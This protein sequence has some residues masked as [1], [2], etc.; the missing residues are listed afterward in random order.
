MATAISCLSS[1]HALL[2][3]SPPAASTKLYTITNSRHRIGFG[4][5]SKNGRYNMGSVTE[6]P[7]GSKP[8]T[9]VAESRRA[10]TWM[11]RASS[12]I[13]QTEKSAENLVD[14][15]LSMVEGTDRGAM[16]RRE[17]HEKIARTISQLELFCM[18]EPLKSPLI[19]GEWDVEY[20]SNPTSTGGYY[21][22]AVGRLFLRTKEMGQ[23]IQAPDF[24]GNKVSFSALNAID[25]EVSLKGRLKPLDNKWVQISFDSPYLKLGPFEFRY[26][27]QSSVK[28][29]IIYVDDRIRLGRGSRGTLFI[30]KRCG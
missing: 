12:A 25:G 19:F 8:P 4:S 9:C 20:C 18:P 13:Q 5:V 29:A 14:T 6:H 22:S 15:L 23:T 28:F 16:L 10:S 1:S 27:G 2:H 3:T 17:E 7:L 21:R 24:V 11:V 30:F 26:G